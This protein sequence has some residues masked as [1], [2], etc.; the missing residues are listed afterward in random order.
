VG[1]ARAAD[2]GRH[3]LPSGIPSSSLPGIPPGISSGIPS[4]ISGRV[5]RD[6]DSERFLGN[7]LRQQRKN[8]PLRTTDNMSKSRVN[9]I[10]PLP[11]LHGVCVAFDATPRCQYHVITRRLECDRIGLTLRTTDNVYTKDIGQEGA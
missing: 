11:I 1:G 2:L 9:L 6:I 5:T 4:G 3:V 7:S 8:T 10:L